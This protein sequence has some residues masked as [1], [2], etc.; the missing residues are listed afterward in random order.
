VSKT[1]VG[2]RYAKALFELLDPATVEAARAA[3]NGLAEAVSQSPQLRHVMASP[4]FSEEEKIDVLGELATRLGCPPTGKHFLAQLVRKNRV[5]FLP[6]IAE[7]FGK[8]ADQAKGIEQVAVASASTLSSQEQ[9][10]IRTSLREL[11]QRNVDVTFHTEPTY[12]AG[13]QIRIGS[14]VV[15]STVRGRLTAMQHLLTRE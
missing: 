8:F 15:D 6:D 12:I 4:A 2:R 1:A 11:L 13:M 7:A 3:M 5:G 9:E 10:R 14:T